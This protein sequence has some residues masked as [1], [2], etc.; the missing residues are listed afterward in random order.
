MRLVAIGEG[1]VSPGIRRPRRGVGRYRG[2]L[3]VFQ[4]GYFGRLWRGDD[5]SGEGNAQYN[6]LLRYRWSGECTFSTRGERAG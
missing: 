5:A 4:S 3:G 2:G 1:L 6:H